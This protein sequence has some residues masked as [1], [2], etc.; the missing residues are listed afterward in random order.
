M[1]A[2][3]SVPAPSVPAPSFPLERRTLDNGLRV[4]LAPDRSA[5]AAAV[6]VHY[7]VGFRSEPEGRTGFAH[8]FEH[9][10]FQGSANLD[11]GEHFRLVQGNGGTLN[12]STRADYTNYFEVLP[13]SALELALFLEADRMRAVRLDEESL[14][15]QIAVVKEEIR[16]NVVNQPY[17][18]FPWIPLPA[19]LFRTFHNAHNG[20]G[21]F[22]DLESATV[23]D[24]AGFFRR[25]YAPGNAVLSV[26][27]D[28]AVEEAHDLVERHF[29]DLPRR[30]VPRRPSFAEP[31]PDGERRETHVDRLAPSPAVAVG[32]RV[33]DPLGDL[34]A[35]LATVVLV[36]VLAEGPASRLYRRLVKEDQLVT[37]LDG[38]LGLFGDPLDARNP[39]LLQVVAF[40]RGD[41]GPDP[42]LA[43][44]DEE[45]ARLEGDL[46]AD[47]VERVISALSSSYLRRADSF[48]E[49]A[50]VLATLEQQR[51]RPELLNELPAA[52]A[53]IT[54]DDVRA[55]AGRVRPDQRG[56]V[57]VQ[58][59]GDR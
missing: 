7:D 4:V 6:A 9:L 45:V 38:Y 10:M 54:V 46:A 36:D 24:A 48:L 20:Y 17:G 49:R 8:L 57:D 5:P 43:A 11:K 30:R 55:A 37:H 12:G 34:R 40:Y 51:G 59:G 52:L 41:G 14:Q 39:T 47:E 28:V 13:S 23:E 1:P 26:V 22:E 50:D 44:V 16:V 31:P 25:Y 33:P 32:Y 42:V 2:R 53:E 27:G 18:G 58:P 29:G 19:V 56:V 3:P 15:N 21:S 35:Y